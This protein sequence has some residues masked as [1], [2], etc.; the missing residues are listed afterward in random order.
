[1][2]YY[3]IVPILD[4]A[5]TWGDSVLPHLNYYTYL[6]VKFMVINGHWD[7]HLK[8]L[9]TSSKRKLNIVF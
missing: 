1:M 3:F 9:V 6:G 7:A 8:D 4:G 2:N 5:W